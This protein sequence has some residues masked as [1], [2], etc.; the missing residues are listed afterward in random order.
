MDTADNLY[1]ANTG[2]PVIRKYAP[3][4]ELELAIAFE[5][6][7]ADQ[8][9]I[10]WNSD[11]SDIEIRRTK[12]ISR[13]LVRRDRSG[14]VIVDKS[15]DHRIDII[16]GIAVDTKGRIYVISARRAFSKEETA[17]TRIS[18]NENGL[19]RALVE[20]VLTKNID[21]YQLLVFD[22]KGKICADIPIVG[23]CDDIY[24][25]GNRVFIID[26]Y[27]NQRILEFE[28]HETP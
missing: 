8:V 14:N 3:G 11:K 6:P 15:G 9:R 27:V 23:T 5:T 7:L 24:I 17:A 19:N 28:V 2:T 20:P 26:G 10:E 21:V 18:G 25:H 16:Q 4:G 1:V 12:E 13:S 22:N